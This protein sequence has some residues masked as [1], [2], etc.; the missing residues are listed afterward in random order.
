MWIV[1]ENVV[2][3]TL[4][5]ADSDTLSRAVTTQP[6]FQLAGVDA[7][8]APCLVDL[9]L[10]FGDQ[11]LLLIDLLDTGGG[12]F[13][14]RIRFDQNRERQ[15]TEIQASDATNLPRHTTEGIIF[16]FSSPYTNEHRQ[17]DVG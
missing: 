15:S 8:R 6:F 16:V 13:E 2:D 10:D 3:A 12:G 17:L 7:M 5:R 14:Q 11:A 4:Q 9:D 1:L